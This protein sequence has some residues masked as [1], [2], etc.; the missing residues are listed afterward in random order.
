LNRDDLGDRRL[1]AIIDERRY[2]KLAG[3]EHRADS[4]RDRLRIRKG[5][6]AP[7]D[8]FDGADDQLAEI[9]AELVASFAADAKYLGLP[10]IGDVGPY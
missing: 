5:K 7:A 10:T 1:E 9:A 2:I 4:L 3:L 6:L 8:I